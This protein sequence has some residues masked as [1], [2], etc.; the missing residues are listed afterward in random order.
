MIPARRVAGLRRILRALQRQVETTW[1]SFSCVIRSREQRIGERAFAGPTCE[2]AKIEQTVAPA[3]AVR[4][5]EHV[6]DH[7]AFEAEQL[8]RDRPAGIHRADGIATRDADVRSRTSR[9]TAKSR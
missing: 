9:R 8:L 7:R 1:S 2:R 5:E 6:G 4:L 3:S